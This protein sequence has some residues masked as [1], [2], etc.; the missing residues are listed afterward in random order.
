MGV[1]CWSVCVRVCVCECVCASVACL[2]VLYTCLGAACSTTDGSVPASAPLAPYLVH[3]RTRGGRGQRDVAG[4]TGSVMVPSQVFVRYEHKFFSGFAEHTRPTTF[5]CVPAC[6]RACSCV[7]VRV[8][9]LGAPH[10]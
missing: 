10:E 2:L 8:R 5:V 6:L 9:V 7:R 4:A 1:V 3:L